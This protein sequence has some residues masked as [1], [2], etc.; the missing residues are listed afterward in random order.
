MSSLQAVPTQ[1]RKST[2]RQLATK[3]ETIR[4]VLNVESE[5]RNTLRSDDSP[6]GIALTVTDG[7]RHFHSELRR[8]LIP[9]L[10]GAWEWRLTIA[11][12]EIHSTDYWTTI[13]SETNADSAYVELE[14]DL[15]GGFQIE[16]QVFVARQDQFVF[17]ADVLKGPAAALGE[18]RIRL[19]VAQGTDWTPAAET[20][21]GQLVAGRRSVAT[22]LPVCLPEWR[23]EPGG[24]LSAR[25]GKLELTMPLRGQRLQAAVFL[26]LDPRRMRKPFTWRR[27]TVGEAL[28]WVPQDVAVG[29][30]V[31]VGK[32]QW[33]IY[34]SLAPRGNRT[35]LG[36]NFSSE[37][38]VA[39]FRSD[40]TAEKLLEIE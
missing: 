15:D 11:N 1:R 14:L 29:Y 40:G 35:V 26:D 19:P 5:R 31:Q 8:G 30:R 22:V 18:Y 39:R 12:A 33:L 37:F 3:S 21:D 13:C 36:Q 34:R 24:T 9:I 28:Q 23:S 38:V 7:G 16:R 4:P 17:L 2:V 25:D 10:T 27:L 6:K 32:S 20:Q